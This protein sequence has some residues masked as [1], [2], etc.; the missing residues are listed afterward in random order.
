MRLLE[1]GEPELAVRAKEL[2]GREN[3]RL[4]RLPPDDPARKLID[5]TPPPRLQYSAHLHWVRKKQEAQEGTAGSA[6][7]KK[8]EP[9]DASKQ[10]HLS[11]SCVEN[12]Q[13]LCF[14]DLAGDLTYRLVGVVQLNGGAKHSGYY[15]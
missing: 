15:L 2:A 12:D 7:K 3:G 10:A 6:R 14:A 11:E 4:T 5:K 1:K 13:S 8:G 9:A